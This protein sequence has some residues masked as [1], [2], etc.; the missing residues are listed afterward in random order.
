MFLYYCRVSIQE[1]LNIELSNSELE[2]GYYDKD[3]YQK[4]IF[5]YHVFEICK[6]FT[7]SENI[8][9]QCFK[10]LQ[11]QDVKD[12]I[13]PIIH[14]FWKENQEYRLCTN[15]YGSLADSIFKKENIKNKEGKI[16]KETLSIY[17]NSLR[18]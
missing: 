14:V 1:G 7:E 16:S 15:I 17:V 10:I 8:C 6:A 3:L 9:K 2:M 11:I 12:R 5:C 18:S 4:C 13:N